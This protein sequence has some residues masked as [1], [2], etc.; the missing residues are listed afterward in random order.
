[1]YRAGKDY[2]RMCLLAIDIYEDYGIDKNCYP[3]DMIYWATKIG[4]DVVPYSAY[5][6]KIDLL[7]KKSKDAFCIP[8]DGIT[9]PIIAYNDMYMCL[10]PFKVSSSLGHEFKHIFEG[11]EDDSEDDLAE[12]FSKYFRCPLPYVLYLNIKTKAELISKFGVSGEQAE[13]VLNNVRNRLNKYGSKYF[14]YELRMLKQ[15]L[16]ES[17]DENELERIKSKEGGKN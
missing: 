10:S 5:P 7:S 11:D 13:Y 1:M 14:D 12:Y 15:I 17:Y 4:I 6:N 2:D 16:N 3:L 8:S 9:K